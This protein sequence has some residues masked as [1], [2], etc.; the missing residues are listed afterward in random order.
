MDD[1]IVISGISGRYPESENVEEFW[2]KLL[3][4]I[5]MYSQDD[6][7][8]PVGKL[9]LFL[10]IF[11]QPNENFYDEKLF[12]IYKRS[13]FK[14]FLADIRGSCLINRILLLL[15]LFLIRVAD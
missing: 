10:K 15:V 6:R 5:P 1:D 13:Q 4:G 11:W 7:R 14:G 2:Y 8:W 3:N 9:V 12:F